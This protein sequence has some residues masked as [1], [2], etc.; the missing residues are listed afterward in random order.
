M[1]ESV[2]GP[3]DTGVPAPAAAGID[4]DRPPSGAAPAAFEEMVGEY[5]SPRTRARTG[6]ESGS[7]Y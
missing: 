1:R 6:A 4:D 3:E 5:G 2:R 7:S